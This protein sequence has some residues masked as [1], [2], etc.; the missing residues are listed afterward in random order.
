MHSVLDAA[1]WV[2]LAWC[3][4]R[5]I[6]DGR[7]VWNRQHRDLVVGLPLPASGLVVVLPW[8]WELPSA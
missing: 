5:P 3:L 7:S 2:L 6:L 8:L 1:P 4:R